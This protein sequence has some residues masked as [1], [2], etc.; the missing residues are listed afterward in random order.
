MQKQFREGIEEMEP[1]L[2]DGKIVLEAWTRAVNKHTAR[3][4]QNVLT[5]MEKLHA[6]KK[7]QVQPDLDCYR[8][9]LITLSRSR[10]PTVGSN[11]PGIFK[12]MEDNRIFPDTS[13]FDAA[14]ETLKNCA[15]H[16]KSEDADKYAKATESMLNR[17]EKESDRSSV[18]IVKPSSV[19][20][21]NVIQALAARK[22]EAA[23]EKAD[24]LLKKMEAA[25]ADGD[26]SMRPT[27][28]SYVGAIHAYGNS[29][30]ESKYLHANE[31][32]QR[33]IKQYSEGNEAARPDVFSFHAVIGACSRSAETSSSADIHKEALLLAI[34]II[35]TMK[36]S[37]SYHPTAKSYL[38]LLQCCSNLLP[39][40]SLE[41]E[42]A[43]RSI[44]RSCCKDGLVN[45]QVLKQFQSAVSSEVYHREV[46]RDAPSYD[47]VK[48][49]PQAWTRGLGYRPRMHETKHGVQKRNPI[50]SVGGDV[51]GS[52]AYSDHRMRK[53]W[54]KK[55]QKLLRGG[56]S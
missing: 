46:V 37:D 3:R 33:M 2:E 11:I 39:S 14:I 36:K 17:M 15:R 51:I 27:R 7:T 47:G 20:Y 42:K 53:V 56:R 13:C 52:T 25:F 48:S 9:V 21:T 22:S 54:S 26:E 32:L 24:E 6:A 40:G 18:S 23:A 49:L 1:S 19:T 35:Q 16:A 31:V 55:N 38:L 12:S 8:Y 4:A 28:D 10:V 29:D 41:M 50:I 45:R 34:S 44:F 43:L 5:T 30:S